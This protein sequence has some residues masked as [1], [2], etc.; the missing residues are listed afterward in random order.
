MKREPTAD[1]VDSEAVYEQTY[2]PT[3]E[4]HVDGVKKAPSA[5]YLSLYDGGEEKFTDQACTIDETTFKITYEIA[6]SYLTT[7]SETFQLKLKFTIGSKTYYALFPIEVVKNK[8]YHGITDDDL[9]DDDPD[10]AD[11]L[12]SGQANFSKQIEAAFQFIKDAL[13]DRRLRGYKVRDPNQINRLVKEKALELIYYSFFK[14]PDDR[15][16][17]RY[18][19]KRENFDV[20][21][22]TVILRYD[23]DQDGTS[24]TVKFQ[25]QTR[26]IR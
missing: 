24:D 22:K 16:F 8:I 12:Y 2:T 11:C 6:S 25:H 10:L 19:I 17:A 23:A 3:F 4:V 18:E 7:T 5:A 1:L 20:L 9:K 26:I 15:W 21:L 13:W 14:Q